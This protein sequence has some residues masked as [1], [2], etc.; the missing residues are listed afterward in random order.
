LETEGA[1]KHQLERISEELNEPGLKQRALEYLIQFLAVDG[2]VDAE[3]SIFL[4]QVKEALK[5][6]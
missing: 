4:D 2:A 1:T 5:T 3:E 6:G